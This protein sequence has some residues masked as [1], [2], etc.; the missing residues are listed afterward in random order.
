MNDSE[1][2]KAWLMSLKEGDEVAIP[3]RTVYR[4]APHI[5][6][7]LKVTTTQIVVKEG[8]LEARYNR[9]DGTRRGHGFN[10]L[11]PVTDE[12]RAAVKLSA[13]REWLYNMTYRREKLDEIPPAVL[14]AM[15]AAYDNGMA[16]H[17]AAQHQSE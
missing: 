1:Q 8:V 2:Y 14:E 12:V 13:N 16:Q 9:H 11:K 17:N 3:D 5:T 15:R 6:R 4:R 10:N 7:V